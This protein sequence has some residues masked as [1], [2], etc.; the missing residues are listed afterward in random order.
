MKSVKKI[1]LRVNIAGLEL[2]NP[3]I[4]ASGTFGYGTEY[5]GMAEP[6]DFGAVITKTITLAPRAGNQPP[7]ICETASGML[8]SIGLA[9]VGF[10]TFKDDKLPRLIGKDT[11]IIANIAGN[12]IEEYVELAGKLNKITDIPALELNISCPNVKQGG[13]AFGIDPA[14]AAALTKAVRK[15]YKKTLIVKLSPNVSDIAA[16]AKAAEKAGADVLSLINTLYGMAVDSKKQ[17]PVLGNIT[18]GLSG[19]AI[20]PVA[21]YNLYKT[22]HSVKIPLIGLGGIMNYTDAIEFMITG[23]SAVQIGTANFVDPAAVKDI[24]IGMAGYCRDNNLNSVTK[25]T[26]I[27]KC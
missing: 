14:S 21:L 13:I 7:R 6:R 4:A 1:D 23:A 9:N 26:G 17:R 19:P 5:S 18:G 27:L 12:T 15:V 11:V 24:I 16:I 25:L 3:V 20:K 22:Y 8:N 2:K 10:E